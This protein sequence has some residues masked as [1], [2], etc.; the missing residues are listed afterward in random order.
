MAEEST[1]ATPARGAP[2]NN[3]LG[4]LAK[5]DVLRQLLILIGIAA[6]VA[7]GMAAVMW[8][9]GT[10]YRTLYTSV[11]PERAGAI[12]EALGNAGIKYRIQDPTGA[13]LVP[14]DRLHEARIKLA[15]QDVMRESGG[16]AMLEQE[17]G[18][19]VSEFM[20]SKK[21][22]YALE[23][24]L[25][26]TVE[27]LQQVR[28]A[29]V[30]LAIPKSSVFIRDRKPPSA[31]IMVD[32]YPGSTV[33]P[34]NVD[35]II[36][37]VASSITGMSAD[38]VTVVDQSGQQL[39]ASKQGGDE[40]SLSQRQF[41]YRQELE[42]AYEQRLSELL[43]PIAGSGR[44]RVQV[45]ADVDFSTTQESR[46]SWNPEGQVV[47]SEQI[48]ENNVSKQ[49]AAA[50]GVPGALSNQ[51]VVAQEA[52]ENEENTRTGSRSVTRNYEIERV[53]N[54]STSPTG[55]IR[56]LSVAVLVDSGR[57][58][59]DAGESV[60]D[61][62]ADTVSQEELDRLTLL[63]KDAVG[64]EEARGDRVTVIA[65]DFRDTTTFTESEAPGF[66]E[67]PWFANLIRQSLAGVGVLFIVFAI[68]RP[69]MR[70]L[71][72]ASS[73]GSRAG[74]GG[75]SHLDGE[76]LPQPIAALGA[77]SDNAASP[78]PGTGLDHHVGEVRNAVDQDPRRVAQVVTRWVSE[79]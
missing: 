71:L 79:E 49:P 64:F 44:V 4:Q 76:Y 30:H 50:S 37:L 29:R 56:R 60:S 39:L 31:S 62:G 52:E 45:A 35:A 48:E 10:D 19:G 3:V 34:K 72:S 61:A 73:G 40:L 14:S 7:V 18:F 6:S 23:Q 77:P 13:I 70:S 24:E 12:V 11:P 32:I 22:H 66:W 69:G 54:Y 27:S 63:V 67:Q 21:Y 57:S 20:Q 9:Q 41:A 53:L 1:N 68:L 8:S 16:M 75:H 46:E 33:G 2:V 51:P 74:G 28:R 42:R 36:N 15:S 55:S 78:V 65:A 26:R 25:A 5:N 47:R 43:R 38:N 59:G 17:Q 58:L